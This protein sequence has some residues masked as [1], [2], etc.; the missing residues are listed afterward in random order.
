MNLSDSSIYSASNKRE[1]LPFIFFNNSWTKTWVFPGLRFKI[2]QE[3]YLPFH[4]FV[5][6]MLFKTAFEIWCVLSF[7]VLGTTHLCLVVFYLVLQHVPVVYTGRGFFRPS[8]AC[9]TTETW[10]Q[11]ADCLQC[12]SI[13]HKSSNVNK[14][15]H[16]LSCVLLYLIMYTRRSNYDRYTF[17]LRI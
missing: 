3:Y 5:I 15:N 16:T 1:I 4:R 6:F 8:K 14:I 11:P 2:F 13:N 9:R 7:I 10:V 12:N 17:I